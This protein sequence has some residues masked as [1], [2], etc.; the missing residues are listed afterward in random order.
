MLMMI[1]SETDLVDGF[2]L[3][4]LQTCGFCLIAGLFVI[5]A[6]TDFCSLVICCSLVAN[7]FGQF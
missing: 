2:W 6:V 1:C 4:L 3:G 7:R 5:L